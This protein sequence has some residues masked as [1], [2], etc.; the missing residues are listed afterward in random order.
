MAYHPAQHDQMSDGDFL[1]FTTVPLEEAN[2]V[3][4]EEVTLIGF[5]HKETFV[6]QGHALI[7]AIEGSFSVADFLMAAHP[8]WLSL[9]PCF[10]PSAYSLPVIQAID[11]TIPDPADLR[12]PFSSPRVQNVPL[13]T[14]K[15]GKKVQRLAKK[16]AG[17]GTYDAIL[18]VV[19]F[20]WAGF[21]AVHPIAAE[22]Q[23]FEPRDKDKR[24]A[25]AGAPQVT[26]HPLVP[27][28]RVYP[29]L[30]PS[31]QAMT[32]F[33]PASWQSAF[34]ALFLAFSA[35]KH[36]DVPNLA[37]YPTAM[38]I[39]A[40]GHGKSTLNRM[41]VNV[42]L[43]TFSQVAF[44]DMDPGQAEFTEPGVLGLTV[45]DFPVLG[46]G[47]LYRPARPL[48]AEQFLGAVT[49]QACP[50]IYLQHVR[51]LVAAYRA[52]AAEAWAKER[53]V[54]PLVVNTLGWVR[55]FGLELLKEA[56]AEVAPTH[57]LHLVGAADRD[58]IPVHEL[59][60][61]WLSVATAAAEAS[62]S[63]SASD[64]EV[65]SLSSAP[66]EDGGEDEDTMVIVDEDQDDDHV[67]ESTTSP[68][69]AAVAPFVPQVIDV[70]SITMS[71]RPRLNASD[72]RIFAQSVA[73]C[74]RTPSLDVPR[75]AWLDPTPLTS[76]KYPTYAIPLSKLVVAT[77]YHKIATPD[78]LY[79]LNGSLVG[80]GVVTDSAI[81]SPARAGFQHV[82]FMPDHHY[83]GFGIVRAIGGGGN[84][85]ERDVYVLTSVDA[86]RLDHVDL[87]I[88][89]DMDVSNWLVTWGLPFV[90]ATKPPGPYLTYAQGEGVGAVAT[91]LRRGMAR[92]VHA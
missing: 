30:H 91:R 16:L 78:L 12:A 84:G 68:P 71:L 75:R 65:A 2:V 23:V 14:S 66:T 9:H 92:K 4:D 45:V 46:P 70:A 52:Y 20:S 73:L 34:Q 3:G 89:G 28:P 47:Y 69:A 88:R 51:T 42:L 11:Y 90:S 29:I 1:G 36:V 50:D 39:G 17:K 15:L 7:A 37:F 32:V 10:G 31:P 27:V 43:S 62:V 63:A 67:E 13:K 21:D 74:S 85:A 41:L 83:V 48:L 40:K 33:A 55:G 80:L 6:F 60:E 54:V 58:Q 8:A 24:A 38:A 35:F 81:A 44:L 26:A 82:P 22:F 72:L 25:L 53:R 49:P 18:A 19:D 56:M 86:A 76:P 5:K 79:A 57:V 87:L 61:P 59:L 77:P 64:G